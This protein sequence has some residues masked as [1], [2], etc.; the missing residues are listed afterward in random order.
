MR[1][2]FQS[3]SRARRER[4]QADESIRRA[5]AAPLLIV[6]LGNPGPERASNRH[7]VGFWCVN[8][9]AKKAALNFSRRGRLA[10]IAEGTIGG[11]EVLLAKPLTFVNRSGEAVREL[12]RRHKIPPQNMI[13]VYDDLD[14]PVA[15]LRIRERGSHGGQNG[16][17][18]IIA[19]IATQD[20]P[21]IRI[22]IGRP[23]VDGQPTRDPEHVAGY[24][25]SNP[26]ASERRQLDGTVELAAE[27]IETAIAEG[28][29]TAMARFNSG[30]E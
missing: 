20:F 18:S 6:G 10:S 8:R 23:E 15:A 17:K 25:L 16:M 2:L 22:G 3:F 9:V 30:R 29:D 26:P 21:R 12:L 13:V 5:E 24:V 4:R 27:A 11:R 7:N 28:I 1:S 14:L 19:A